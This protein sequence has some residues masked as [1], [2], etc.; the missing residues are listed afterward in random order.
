[1]IAYPGHGKFTDIG[2]E[3]KENSRVTVDGG[4]W[5]TK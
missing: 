3:K 1:M 5:V 2:S 4:A